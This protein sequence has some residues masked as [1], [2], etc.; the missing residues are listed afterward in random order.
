MLSEKMW[1]GPSA[2]VVGLMLLVTLAGCP[3]E[4]PQQVA[5]GATVGEKWTKAEQGPVIHTMEDGKPTVAFVTN[6]IAGFWLI[7]EAGVNKAGEDFDANVI[8]RMPPTGTAEEQRRILEELLT[9]GVDGVAVTPKDPENLTDIL[10]TVAENTNLIT[11]DSDAPKSNRLCYVGMENY[12]AGRLC[13]ALIK[14]ALPDG[15]KLML[16]VG[17]LDQD[18]AIGRR[19]GII[20][21]LLGRD[22]DPSRNDPANAVIESDLYTIIGTKTDNFDRSMA[23]SQVEDTLTAHPDV[24]ALIGLFEY[25]PPMI[26]EALRGADK[27]G[28][29]QVIGFDENDDTLQAIEDGYCYGTVVQDPY[30]YGYESVRI[31]AALARGDESVLPDG[32]F[33][34]I[35]ARKITQTNVTGFWTELKALVGE[36]PAGASA[37]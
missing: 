26:L 16:F 12:D 28:Q 36:S 15:G 29:V 27:L 23:K 21:E 9:S 5:G 3:G 8:V 2:V 13:G 14:E 10:N 24:A 25:N 6:C 35:P 30:H 31:L 33:V 19:Q 17:N 1:R 18:N 32:R 37:P 34:D 11:H 22:H 20:D 7:A 4:V